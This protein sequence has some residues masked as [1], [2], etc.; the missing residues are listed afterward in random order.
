MLN[1]KC[2]CVRSGVKITL[3]LVLKVLKVIVS[4]L[5]FFWR[6]PLFFVKFLLWQLLMRVFCS[7]VFLLYLGYMV[8]WDELILAHRY[9]YVIQN[10]AIHF[11]HG[12]IWSWHAHQSIQFVSAGAY[13]L[14]FLVCGSL[15]YCLYVHGLFL[16][17]PSVFACKRA[18][19][20]RNMSWGKRVVYLCH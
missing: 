7:W 20:G 1:A 9:T 8:I 10:G 17:F 2:V 15:G 13:M 19:S 3:G 6:V 18:L 12:L 16:V 14:L 11:F 4:L 5:P